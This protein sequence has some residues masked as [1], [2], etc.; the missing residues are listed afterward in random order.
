MRVGG[1]GNNTKMT[2]L[3]DKSVKTYKHL[4]C[5]LKVNSLKS[6]SVFYKSFYLVQ[7]T[8]LS[9]NVIW[10]NES[11]IDFYVERATTTSY[12]LKCT[13]YIRYKS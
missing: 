13:M 1:G 10:I 2:C 9:I 7:K 3:S 12:I 8:N 5:F 11:V 4:M 6:K